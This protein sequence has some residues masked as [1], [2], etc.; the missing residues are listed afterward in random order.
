MHGTEGRNWRIAG[1]ASLCLL[2][3]TL[4]LIAAESEADRRL[5]E[6]ISARLEGQVSLHP[7]NLAVAVK[8]GSVRLT[9]SVASLEEVDAMDRLVKGIVEVREVDNRVSVRPS[10]RSDLAIRQDLRQRLDKF[11]SLRQPSVEAVV[12]EGRAVL[13]GRVRDGVDRLEADRQ[14]RSVAG[15]VSLEN[16]IEVSVNPSGPPGHASDG[17]AVRVRSLLGNPLT[18]GAVRQLRVEVDGSTVYLYGKVSRDA[19]RDEA[20]KLTLTVA[21]VQRVVNLIAVDPT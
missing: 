7:R 6:R 17:L 9:G 18:F 1:M 2:A 19:D 20:G 5:R 15:V 13:T 3:A 4:H 16:R 8:D 21:G 10:T 14:A 12:K 11:P